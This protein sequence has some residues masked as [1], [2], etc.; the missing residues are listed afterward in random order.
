[1]KILNF[2]IAAG[3][4]NAQQVDNDVNVASLAENLDKIKFELNEIL[5]SRENERDHLEVFQCFNHQCGSTNSIFVKTYRTGP[6]HNP[7]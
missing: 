2:F 3:A 1:M 4:I 6:F 5:L 7:I